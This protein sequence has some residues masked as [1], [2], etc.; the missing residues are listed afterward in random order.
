MKNY[1]IDERTIAECANAIIKSKKFGKVEFKNNHKILL[2]KSGLYDDIV[3][4]VACGVN[5]PR[6]IFCEYWNGTL[7]GRVVNDELVAAYGSEVTDEYNSI[8]NI[9]KLRKEYL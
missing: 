8:N 1:N 5:G 4:Q 6:A 3:Y 2:V 7:K 9:I